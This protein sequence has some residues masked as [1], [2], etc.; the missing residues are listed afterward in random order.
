MA[1]LSEIFSGD[2]LSLMK[3]EY[4]IAEKR[5]ALLL[6]EDQCIDFELLRCLQIDNNFLRHLVSEHYDPDE[7]DEE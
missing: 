1:K 4:I 6:S 5:L 3:H 2:D 7:F